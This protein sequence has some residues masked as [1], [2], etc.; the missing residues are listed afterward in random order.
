MIASTIEK[1]TLN[2]SVEI[3]KLCVKSL[4]NLTDIYEN[5]ILSDWVIMPNHVHFIIDFLDTPISKIIQKEKNLGDII[6]SFK[7][8]FQKSIVEAT[9]VSPLLQVYFKQKSFNYHKI[10]QKS[11][12]DHVIRNEKDLDKIR[13]YI[14]NNP[15]QW[16]LDSLNP[17]NKNLKFE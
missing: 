13:E 8:H 15:E 11:F 12:Y 17:Y 5:I 4:I 16:E 1:N 9:T 7:L 6:K 3:T 10:W 14:Y 2:P